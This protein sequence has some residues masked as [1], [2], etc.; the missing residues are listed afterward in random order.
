LNEKRRHQGLSF[1]CQKLGQRTNW[2]SHEWHQKKHSAF[3]GCQNAYT[4]QELKPTL[5]LKSCITAHRNIP[6]RNQNV[7]QVL[8]SL[9]WSL[10]QTQLHKS[11]IH[12]TDSSKLLIAPFSDN[13]YSTEAIAASATQQHR[14]TDLLGK[15]HNTPKYLSLA[16]LKLLSPRRMSKREYIVEC[17]SPE[18]IVPTDLLFYLK[19]QQI[20]VLRTNLSWQAG[21]SKTRP[22]NTA[23][24][25]HSAVQLCSTISRTLRLY[26]RRFSL[27][28]RAA[29]EFAGELGLGSHSKDCKDI[30]LYLS[31]QTQ[32]FVTQELAPFDSTARIKCQ[33]L[34]FLQAT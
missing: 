32:R 5:E 9:Y 27:Y 20:W 7:L 22:H 18:Q 2:L 26:S 16:Q 13:I 6:I 1:S 11:Q 23:K 29:S 12:I 25:Y 4:F 10:A 33:Q 31:T 8:S 15:F 24:Q 21:T 19:D 34:N 14:S 30:Y 17:R 28:M 3:H